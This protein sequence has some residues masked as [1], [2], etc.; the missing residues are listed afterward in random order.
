VISDVWAKGGY[1]GL[2][3]AEAVDKVCSQ[4]SPNLQLTYSTDAS[5]EE[6]ISSI[7]TK[8]YRGRDVVYSPAA[9]KVLEQ[10]KQQKLTHLPVCMAK[11]QYS[12]SDN[13]KLT[14][15]PEN[16]SIEIRELRIAAGAGFIVALTGE[17]MTMPGLPV[18]AAAENIDIDREGN[19]SG[20][21]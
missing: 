18:I 10:I 4:S 7:V 8:I 11:T 1:G 15:A 20:L 12:F 14:G 16:F 21:F 9:R 3:L 19:I 13:P 6:K 5:I 17:I 2:E